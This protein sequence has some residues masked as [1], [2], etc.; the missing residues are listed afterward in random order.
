MRLP[1]GKMIRETEPLDLGADQFRDLSD[2][3]ENLTSRRVGIRP[4]LRGRCAPARRSRR[5]PDRQELVI[6]VVGGSGDTASSPAAAARSRARYCD[7]R[8]S[9]LRKEF[10]F[11]RDVRGVVDAS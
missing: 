7:G 10:D 1:K 6:S 9:V 2:V 8:D 4:G 5:H 3:D 11:G